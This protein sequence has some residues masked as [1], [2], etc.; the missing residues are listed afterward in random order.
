MRGEGR[1]GEESGGKARR[2]EERR[3][4]YNN[5]IR[6]HKMKGWEKVR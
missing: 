5:F 3:E 1:R 2:R 6:G 4:G